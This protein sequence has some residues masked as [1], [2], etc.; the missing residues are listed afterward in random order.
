MKKNIKKSLII[1]SIVILLNSFCVLVSAEEG[2]YDT[3]FNRWKFKDG[4]CVG[5]FLAHYN[6]NQYPWD[7]LTE[8]HMSDDYEYLRGM[9]NEAYQ[10]LTAPSV[11]NMIRETGLTKEEFIAAQNKLVE[12]YDG[13]ESHRHFTDEEI[14]VLYSGDY[15]LLLKT[16]MNEDAFFHNNRVYTE[17]EIRNDLSTAEL[18]E[19]RD[20]SDL[21]EYLEGRYAEMIA[22]TKYCELV[23]P[24][25]VTEFR[26]FIDELKVAT[27]PQTSLTTIIYAAV[28]ALALGVVVV[29]K[30]RG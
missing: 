20:N 10:S 5:V 8:L 24:T 13:D 18:V 22:D 27:A 26:E 19:L 30:K 2:G 1:V 23:G 3:N 4:F 7:V 6:F 25:V 17:Y 11:Y 29:K 21:I 14:D 16:F 9:G 28:A 15:T 12:T